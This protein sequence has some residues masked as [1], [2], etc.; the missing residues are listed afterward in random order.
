MTIEDVVALAETLRTH[1]RTADGRTE[2]TPDH[3]RVLAEFF[4]SRDLNFNQ[5]QWIDDVAGL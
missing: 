3:L 1:N 5:Q 4:A 2:F